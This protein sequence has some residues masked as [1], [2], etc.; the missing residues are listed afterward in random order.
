MSR[1]RTSKSKLKAQ[2]NSLRVSPTNVADTD[3]V[4]IMTPTVSA[5]DRLITPSVN[6]TIKFHN[7]VITNIAPAPLYSVPALYFLCFDIP[8]FRGVGAVYD[9][10]VNLPHIHH[11]SVQ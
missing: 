10:F 5:I 6:R 4:A 11:H 9:Y 2:T 7:P 3:A 8:S 1:F